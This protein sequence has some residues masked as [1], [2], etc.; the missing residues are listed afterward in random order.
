MIG[1]WVTAG[2]VAL[3]VVATVAHHRTRYLAKPAASAGF[4]LVV[5]LEPVDDTAR[6]TFIVVGLVLGAVGDIALMGRGDG[7]FLAG[8]GAFLAGHIAYV[9]AFWFD[10]GGP[11]A[12]LTGAV[13]ALALAVGV[14]GWLRARLHG[15]FRIAVPVYIVVICAM[16][17]LAIGAS[18]SHPTAAVGA[19]L[20]AASD[21]F[22]A[23]ERFV[24]PA[25]W[26]PAVGLPLYYAGQLLI[27]VSAVTWS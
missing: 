24:E 7:P 19:A 13:V 10:Q 11:P 26:N 25:R 15:P 1:L 17:A 9:I 16:V 6:A 2:A 5:A 27:A 8:L 4:L 20:F 23:R 18:P 12:R 3:L 21:L 22:V 14:G